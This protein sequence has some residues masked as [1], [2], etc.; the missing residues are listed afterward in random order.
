MDF[1]K[2]KEY[3]LNGLDENWPTLYKIRYIYLKLGKII[4]KDTDFF[5]SVDHKLGEQNLSLEDIL[6]RYNDVSGN[7]TEI[8]C[9][10]SCTMLQDIYK[11]IGIK[12]ELIK[13][14]N[15]VSYFTEGNKT[16]TLNH[17]ILAVYD[18]NNAYFMTL[19]SD[20]PYIQ[21]DM[22][23]EHFAIN[24]P[25]I[26][27]FKDGSST[28]VYEGNEIKHTVLKD[29]ELKQIDEKI[30]YLKYKYSYNTKSKNEPE[31]KYGNESY[32][33]IKEAI[34]NNKLYYDTIAHNTPFYQ[35]L[36]NFYGENKLISFDDITLDELS[37]KD[38]KNW[39]I[40]LCYKVSEK[41]SEKTL[42][43]ID[44]SIFLEQNWDYQKWLKN[45]CETY[46]DFIIDSNSDE[47]KIDDNF[48][49]NKWSKKIKQEIGFDLYDYDSILT[50]ID[51]TNALVNL[52]STK[53]N[54]TFND[55]L[56]KLSFHFVPKDYILSEEDKK[57]G[58]S[59][60]YIANKLKTL[61]PIIF[62]A[63]DIKTPFNNR[64]YSEQIVIIKEIIELMFPE[65]TKN[66]SS[67]D[68]NDSYSAVFNRIHFYTIKNRKNGDYSIVLNIIG[69]NSS[70]DYY[71]FYDP[72]QNIFKIANILEIYQDYIIVSDRFKTR[73]EELESMNSEE[74]IK[75]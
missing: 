17:W 52:I 8:I 29:E 70:G 2:I 57:K 49:Y 30:G 55:L 7:N 53:K 13:S 50:I 43:S 67:I 22:Q 60:S 42:L 27:Y 48:V 39:I 4:S 54:G 20:L 14:K 10:T 33:L 73:L 35:S 6:N 37:E 36:Y 46:K 3:V 72:K 69:N 18:E 34:K 40:L 9:K 68:Y 41:I 11:S 45:I 23:T 15:N 58:I 64:N 21:E 65:L 26:K 31:V 38:I 51:K 28:Q 47:Y 66:N 44:K 19:S 71:F 1:D 24:I 16:I 32:N 63:N 56:C 62:S 59:N 75:R 5:F 74:Q 12:S 61:F 25:Y